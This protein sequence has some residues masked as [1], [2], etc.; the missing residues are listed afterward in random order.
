MSRRLRA[1]LDVAASLFLNG[2]PATARV[3]L[4]DLVNAPARPPM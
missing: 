1:L 2:D 4:R 3:V